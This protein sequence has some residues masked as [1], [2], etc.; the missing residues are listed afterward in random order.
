VKIKHFKKVIDENLNK[1]IVRYQTLM[2]F[3]EVALFTVDANDYHFTSF[4]PDSQRFFKENFQIEV[5]EGIKIEDVFQ[6]QEELLIYWISMF[7]KVKREGE[8]SFTTKSPL[9]YH[10]LRVTLKPV[11]IH[12]EIIEIMIMF[13][14]VSSLIENEK[15]KQE[16][17]EKFKAVM[18]NTS[19]HIYLVD[20]INFKIIYRNKASLEFIK[21]A[22]GSSDEEIMSSNHLTTEQRKWWHSVFTEVLEKKSLQFRRQSFVGDTILD[23][24]I[25]VINLNQTQ[26][27]MVLSK[28]VTESVKYQEKL[29]DVNHQVSEQLMKSILAISK[30]GELRDLY[31]AGHQRR[32]AQLA[33]AIGKKLGLSQEKIEIIHMGSIIH[34]IGKINI[35]A[36]IL[37][38]PDTLSEYEYGIVKLHP[39]KGHSIIKDIGLPT[40]VSLMILQHHERLDGSG[41]PFGLKDSEIILESRILM[42]ADVVEAISSHRPY[43]PALGIEVALNEIIMHRGTRFDA[44]VVDACVELMRHE[45]FEFDKK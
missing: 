26:V 43:R 1:D 14:D 39:E 4:G 37:S 45:G 12:D 36:E 25:Q 19:D 11:M 38:K 34:D 23:F 5:L 8:F 21:Q 29:L 27:I 6:H 15:L 28:D 22:Y 35:P 33:C 20:V 18:E 9:S 24:K 17:F 7:E 3:N 30:I 13:S 42:V 16:E 32:V 10:H 40:Q 44:S 41:Y 31:T 2:T